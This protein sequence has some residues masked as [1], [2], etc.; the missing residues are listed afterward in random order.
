[1]KKLLLVAALLTLGSL[2]FAE[3]EIVKRDKCLP[4]T[5]VEAEIGVDAC[6]YYPIEAWG[7]SMLRFGP[8]EAG[9]TKVIRPNH[10]D[11]GRIFVKGQVGTDIL[12][13]YPDHVVLENLLD[14]AETIKVY[15]IVVRGDADEKEVPDGDT[16]RIENNITKYTGGEMLRI[17]GA[18]K[19]DETKGAMPGRYYGEFVMNF[20][21][22]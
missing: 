20:Q 3:E 8:I 14:K 1:M 6:V 7:V 11:R 18:I 22:Q 16:V 15:P 2:A 10:P 4:D 19:G 17:G 5:I 21:Y 9:K 12:V 13:K